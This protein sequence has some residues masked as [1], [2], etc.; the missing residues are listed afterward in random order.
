[1]NP[2]SK[3]ILPKYY[4]KINQNMPKEY[5]N[6]EEFENEW[7]NID[8]YEVI[9]KIGRGKYSEV[10][11]GISVTPQKRIVIKVLKPVKKS[12][13]KREIKILQILKGGPNIVELQDV[14]RDSASKTPALIFEYVENV[15]F[16]SLFP[17][18]TDYEIRYYLYELMKAL[19]YCHSKGIMHRDI[20]PQ[21]I[22]VDPKNKILKLIDWGLAEFYHPEQNYNVRVAS[23]YFKGPELLVDQ[24]YYDYSLDIWSSGV[25][26]A[27]MIFK[28]EPF[29]QG[30]DNQDQLVKIAKV[31]GTEDLHK[32]IKKYDLVLDPL[33]NKIL[34]NYPKKPWNKFTNDENKQLC[35]DQAIDLLSKMLIYDHAQRITPKDAMEHPYFDIVKGTNQIQKK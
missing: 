23:R 5:W 13:I 24:N 14:V 3:V 34:G 11:D 31:L 18:L 7:G 1:M 20:K 29:F 32:Y 27:S 12:K 2:Q 22:I 19:D 8:N 28:K 9:R 26:F 6:Y 4:S 30:A 10:F 33:Y 35:N 15:D 16:R 25:M 17:Q 21:N